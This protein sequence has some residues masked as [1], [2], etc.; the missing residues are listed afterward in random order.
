M[1]KAKRSSK[2]GNT[3]KQRPASCVDAGRFAMRLFLP[4]HKLLDS[5]DQLLRGLVVGGGV[6]VPVGS[7]AIGG[8][9]HVELQA[10]DVGVAGL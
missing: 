2:T 6:G 7:V 4:G 9:L 3:T 5:L 8:G 1:K 10:A